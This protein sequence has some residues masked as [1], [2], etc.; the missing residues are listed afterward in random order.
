[1]N[2][3][4]CAHAVAEVFGGCGR[5]FP[6]KMRGADFPTKEAWE[7]EDRHGDAVPKFLFCFQILRRFS[8]LQAKLICLKAPSGMVGASF[9]KL[10]IVQQLSAQFP[11]G[12]AISSINWN[13]SI[14]N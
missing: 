6:Q 2:G 9:F 1:M 12:S 3:A 13:W 8:I 7:A 11:Q 14:R 10:E 5:C 4:V